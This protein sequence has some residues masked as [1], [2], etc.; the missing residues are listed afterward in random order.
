MVRFLHHHTTLFI[1]MLLLV[2]ILSRYRIVQSENAIRTCKIYAA[3]PYGFT[4]STWRFLEEELYPKIT[5]AGCTVLDP[6]NIKSLKEDKGIVSGL[7]QGRSNAKQIKDDADGIVAVLDGPDVDSGTA[8]EIGYAA[9]IGKW[10]IGYRRDLRRTGDAPDVTVNLQ[11]E[12]FICLNGGEIVNNLAD[13]TTAI[14]ARVGGEHKQN[15][16]CSPP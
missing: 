13:I 8:A 14:R 5:S 3:S 7:K 11:V 9:G 10:V 12:Y 15:A 6:W 2:L 16:R 4:P 1:I